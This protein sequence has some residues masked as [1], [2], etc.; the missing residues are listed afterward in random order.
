MAWAFSSIDSQRLV[1]AAKSRSGVLLHSSG[2]RLRET[3][4]VVKDGC[5]LQVNLSTRLQQRRLDHISTRLSLAM[6]GTLVFGH[7]IEQSCMIDLETNILGQ[8]QKPKSKF[9][10]CL[11]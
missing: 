11:L 8:I 2:K 1:L 5:G 7:V 6:V 4:D 3:I 10:V 9:G